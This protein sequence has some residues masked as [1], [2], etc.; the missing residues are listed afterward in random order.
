MVQSQTFT[1]TVEADTTPAITATA[2]QTA[3]INVAFTLTLPESTDGNEPL[4]YSISGQPSWVSFDDDTRILSGTPSATG[5]TTITYT[6]TDAN[7]DTATDSFTISV[8]GTDV[9]VTIQTLAQTVEGGVVVDLRATATG[10]NLM[11]SWEDNPSSGVFGNATLLVTTW[12]AP[13]PADDTPYTLTLTVEDDQ[14]NEGVATVVITV[15]GSTVTTPLITMDTRTDDRVFGGAWIAVIP[16]ISNPSS[17]P[18]TYL[19]TGTG[20][21]T[22]QNPSSASTFLRMP[23]ATT[24]EQAVSITLTITDDVTMATAEA[25]L[26][27][28]VVAADN[29]RPTRYFQSRCN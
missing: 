5:T 24:A 17:N 2:D 29:C 25:D 28:R 10:T 20:G 3:T 4:V 19:W 14:G 23:T 11:N 21:A 8:A 9:S 15:R 18:L 16:T 1:L 7:D 22:I 6:V 27:L 13:T 12:T 26:D